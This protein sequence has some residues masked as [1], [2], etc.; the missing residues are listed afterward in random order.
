MGFQ[1]T[2]RSGYR[3]NGFQ[4]RPLQALGY[5]SIIKYSILSNNFFANIQSFVK[6]TNILS[7]FFLFIYSRKYIAGRNRIRNFATLLIGL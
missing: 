2:R 7:P 4:V 5:S 6:K 3:P 1:P